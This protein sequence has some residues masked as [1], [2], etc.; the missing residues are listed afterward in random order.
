[1]SSSVPI[2][3]RHQEELPL[4]PQLLG[5]CRFLE[6]ALGYFPFPWS[7]AF[8]QFTPDLMASVGS[9]SNPLS[10][11]ERLSEIQQSLDALKIKS[12][13]QGNL[14]KSNVEEDHKQW[15]KFSS[16]LRSLKN[17]LKEAKGGMDYFQDVVFSQFKDAANV[18]GD[19]GNRISALETAVN[20]IMEKYN[21]N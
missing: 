13:A 21:S 17:D 4:L 11:E 10:V 15:K 6:T 5:F 18:T 2:S 8:A 19:F 16:E 7:L 12:D 9:S 14:L 3:S 1:M 20:K